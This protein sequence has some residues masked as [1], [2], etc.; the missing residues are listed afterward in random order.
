MEQENSSEQKI[1][2]SNSCGEGR[3]ERKEKKMQS[4]FP[5]FRKLSVYDD[6]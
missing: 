6:L 4:S 1:N 2:Q 5:G 3:E